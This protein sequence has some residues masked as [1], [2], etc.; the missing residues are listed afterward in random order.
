M[1]MLDPDTPYGWHEASASWREITTAL[2]LAA[3]IMLGA[4]LLF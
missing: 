3:T 4:L 1:T 2:T